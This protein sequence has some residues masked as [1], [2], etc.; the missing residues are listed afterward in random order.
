MNLIFKYKIKIFTHYIL[1]KFISRHKELYLKNKI[2]AFEYS[3]LMKLRPRKIDR[4][5]LKICFIH[6]GGG[7]GDYLIQLNYIKKF[8]NYFNDIDI[9]VYGF[10]KIIC[11]TDDFK[12]INF[13][14]NDEI[15]EN[16]NFYDVI[17]DF[18]RRFIKPIILQKEYLCYYDKL[19]RNYLLKSLSFYNANKKIFND[20][21]EPPSSYDCISNEIGLLHG[22]KTN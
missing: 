12:D 17:L 10:N 21:I 9:D 13:F 11:F 4:N 5:K 1:S 2:K 8:S 19:L 22:K 18:Q 6:L 3:K 15:N 7:I 20:N 14:S 16:I